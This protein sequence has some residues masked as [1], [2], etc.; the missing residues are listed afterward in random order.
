MISTIDS[1]GRLVIPKAIR[2]QAGLRAGV[3]VE[4]AYRDGHIEI[5]PA[6][7][8]V[9]LVRKGRVVFAR[10]EQGADALA[11]SVVESTRKK[12]RER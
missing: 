6:P 1:A 5:A 9:A 2:E 3:P 10:P 7:R 11:T 12:L 8:R 4:I